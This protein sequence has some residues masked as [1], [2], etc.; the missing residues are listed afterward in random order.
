MTVTRED[1]DNLKQDV[2]D[3]NASIKSAEEDLQFGIDGGADTDELARM[4]SE[5]K[6]KQNQAIRTIEKWGRILDEREGT[7]HTQESD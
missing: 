7:S 5:A 4:L 2:L 6:V 1:I 3:G